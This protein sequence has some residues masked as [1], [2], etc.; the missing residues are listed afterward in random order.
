ME[1]R[2]GYKRTD[3]GLIPE[4]WEVKRIADFAYVGSGGTPS[5]EIAAYWGDLF[6]GLQHPKLTSA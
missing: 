3:I 6:H 4:Q 2:P 1:V 5:R